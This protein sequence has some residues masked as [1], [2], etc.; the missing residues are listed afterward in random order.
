MALDVHVLPAD[1]VPS[2]AWRRDAETAILS[3]AFAVA[4]SPAGY[5]GVVELHDEDGALAVLDV[6]GGVLCGIDL[7][8]W[9]EITVLPGLTA[10]V[11]ARRAQVMVPS[12]SVRRGAAAIEFD[13]TLSISAD[14]DADAEVFHLRI[15]TRRPVEPL[16]IADR[17]LV[18]IDAGQR[19]AGFWLEAVPP[20]PVG[21]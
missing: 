19:L 1:G 8:V 9:P 7:V 21:S 17:M 20:E 12:R 4:E 6:H 2:L 10:P 18:E 11:D 3:G 5:T 15:G 14:A 16:R 13:T